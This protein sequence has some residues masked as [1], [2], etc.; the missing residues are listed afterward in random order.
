MIEIQKHGIRI[1]VKK[2]KKLLKKWSGTSGRGGL[3]GCSF[4]EAAHFPV[5]RGQ[6]LAA[7]TDLLVAEVFVPGLAFARKMHSKVKACFP[8]FL[9]GQNEWHSGLR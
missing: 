1:L 6:K 9:W 5:F 2:N 4:R 7:V 8:H 3:S